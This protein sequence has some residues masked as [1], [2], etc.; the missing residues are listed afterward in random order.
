[1]SSLSGGAA[2]KLGN[3]YETLWTLWRL[4]GVLDGTASSLRLEPPGP[5][6][7]GIE[8]WVEDAGGRWFEQAKLS[9][10]TWTVTRLINEGVLGAL[11][12]HVREGYYARLVTSARSDLRPLTNRARA[13]ESLD[14]YFEVVTE[15][16][17]GDFDRL[18]R[19]LESEP[20]TL[21][22]RL[23]SLYVEQ[24]PWETLQPL[25]RLRYERL[26]QGDPELVINEL[27]GWLTDRLHET[28][29]GPMVWDHLKS[30]GLR[31][32]LLA[33]D[34]STLKALEATVSRHQRRIEATQPPLAELSRPHPAAATL[35]EQL[36]AGGEQVVVVDGGAGSGKSTLLDDALRTLAA[37][38]WF[39]CL[40]RM[41]A[42]PQ[43]TVTA[44][45]LGKASDLTDSPAI[46][47]DGV[48]DGSPA[49]LVIDQL[50]AISTYSGRMADN[51]DAAAELLDQVQGMPNI[52]T[53]VA[54][55]TVDLTSD[56]R[57][58]SLLS[59]TNRV[60]RVYV[61]QLPR[62]SVLAA[63]GSLGL[64]DG[65]VDNATVELL[66]TPLHL[67]VFSRL[68]PESRQV[69]H[70]TLSDLYRELTVEVRRDVE[71]RVGHL[72]WQG[73]V[74]ALVDYMNQHETLNAPV[75][76][77]DPAHPDEVQGLLSAGVL[78]RDGERV[79]FFHETY[80]DY[81][82]AQGFVAAGKDL[83]DFLVQ[84]SQHLF[85]R[86]Q[87]R[88]VLDY[89][90]ATDRHTLRVAVRRLLTS[91]QIRRHLQGVVTTVLRELDAEPADWTNLEPIAFGGQPMARQVRSLLATPSW[92]DA[93]DAASRWEPLLADPWTAAAVENQL[94]IV[95]RHRPER[96][97][98]LVRP[99]VA[100]S[101]EWRRRLRAI[102]EWSIRPGLTDLAVELIQAGQV[103]DAR[104]PIA[105]NS[106]FWSIVYGLAKED[107][108][109][110]ARVTG[111]YLRRGAARAANE[112]HVDPFSAGYLPN[113]SAGGES[114]IFD[115]ATT[116]PLA[117]VEEVLPF[118][119]ALAEDTASSLQPQALRRTPLWRPRYADTV[120][121][122][123]DGVF[124]GVE[125]ALRSVA[126]N[127]PERARALAAPLV[128]SDVEELRFLACRALTAA[129]PSDEAIDWLLA[130]DRNLRLG[131][132]DSPA[133]AARELIQEATP[134]CSDERITTLSHRL[135]QYYPD[136]ER[137][138]EARHL[139][140]RRQY[141]LLS[142][143][144]RTRLD[145]YA[146]RRLKE[147]ERRF[148][149]APPAPPQPTKMHA[150]GPPVPEEA[151]RHL[152]D[153]DWLR[154]IHKYRNRESDWSGQIPVGGAP[155]LARVLG[156][157][158][159]VEPER[160]ADLALRFDDPTPVEH[161]DSIIRA[162]AGKI[163]TAAL[164]RLCRHSRDVAGEDVGHAI[165][166]A[167]EKAGPDVDEML[168]ALL[169]ECATDRDP[170]HEAARTQA[171]SDEED[172]LAAGLNSTRGGAAFAATKLLYASPTDAD[173]LATLVS[174]LAQDPLLAVKVWAAN[175]ITALLNHDSYTALRMAERLFEDERIDIFDTPTTARLLTYS[176]HR[177]P[178]IFAPH[179]RRA[180]G[181]HEAV[182]RRAGGVWAAAYTRD[183]LTSPVPEDLSALNRPA[184]LGAANALQGAPSAAPELVI[185]LLDDDDPDVRQAAAAVMW[186]IDEV[187]PDDADTLI[188]AFVD[189]RAYRD[190]FD[191][192]FRA[193]ER[194][195]HLLTGAVL[196]ACERAVE[197]AGP[198]LADIQ[199]RQAGASKD[200]ITVLLRLYRQGNSEERRRCLDV[201]DRLVELGAYGLEDALSSER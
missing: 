154:A 109:A 165:C 115:L 152:S 161:F 189:S 69:P 144:D 9:E 143:V 167:V 21:W 172:L 32:R 65:D 15:V 137:T 35:V 185:R 56:P 126:A 87:T 150:V 91:D 25:V 103:D 199:T 134:R 83:H 16:E 14:E 18:C 149:N 95:A 124:H 29:T 62:E 116:A 48:A 2:D 57:L 104:G 92:F 88:Q 49:V 182:A 86:A 10:Q 169:E 113:S 177:E 142:A 17:R 201:I 110:A 190:H 28:V 147:L 194:S 125:S 66:R 94:V 82:F 155:E 164:S 107:A 74:G 72:D 111:A 77:L 64:Q 100:E 122:I 141:E 140:G 138:A 6:G 60:T 200:L 67:A 131:W 176:L 163:P 112:G 159:E 3:R 41:D 127:D 156:S 148:A 42:A 50:D 120:Y 193:L 23:Q 46:L 73:I 26:V 157:R 30:R 61:D 173:R 102:I 89:L 75:T 84:S 168:L 80:F 44:A 196:V 183:L 146:E 22:N 40:I 197:F 129:Q 123:A 33:G 31:R 130:D 11:L 160:F 118:V 43:G 8:F 136:W 153:E 186:S 55:R 105:V 187:E 81:L 90:A 59:D 99:Y 106:D 162:V 63:L 85:R 51:Y 180:L 184:R 135:L 38:G 132:T 198:S 108:A 24:Y 52:K 175:A 170:D 76:V 4:A 139:R 78:I 101:E 181:G 179:L 121:T 97:A 71:R 96:V 192:L 37:R 174:E 93:A 5:A 145:E 19:T 191:R 58:R 79:S 98:E 20:V 114:H 12:R 27:A 119:T 39:S 188:A 178:R 133:W 117:F 158:A 166:H 36:R 53:V 54:V 171:G 128:D 45:G 7:Q 1:M 68:S 151:A 34:S 195:P 13:S 70:R 47:L